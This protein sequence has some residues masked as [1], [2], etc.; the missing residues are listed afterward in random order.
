MIKWPNVINLLPG[1][2]ACSPWKWC[3][4]GSLCWFPLLAG[5]TLSSNSGQISL[6]GGGMHPFI[7]VTTLPCSTAHWAMTGL[8]GKEAS[9]YPQD[10]SSSHL[11]IKIPLY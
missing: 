6:D 2:A 11:T 7:P 5:W 3:H 1:V 9:W 4:V 8:A 10:G